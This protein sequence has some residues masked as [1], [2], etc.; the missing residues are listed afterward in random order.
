MPAIRASTAAG[1]PLPDRLRPGEHH[2]G[3]FQGTHDGVARAGLK[4]ARLLLKFG[5]GLPGHSGARAA[6]SFCSSGAEPVLP[7]VAARTRFDAQASSGPR[8]GS[9]AESTV[10]KLRMNWCAFTHTGV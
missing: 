2:A 6:R 4:P 1:L 10:P 7:G 3:I 8:L 5:D 9:C